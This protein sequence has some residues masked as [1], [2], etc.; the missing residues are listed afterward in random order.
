VVKETS[1]SARTLTDTV[2][3]ELDQNV[4]TSE[5][6]EQGSIIRWHVKS[7]DG[8]GRVEKETDVNQIIGE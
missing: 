5:P 4:A 2:F 6:Y 7:Y 3:N 8:Y 1:G